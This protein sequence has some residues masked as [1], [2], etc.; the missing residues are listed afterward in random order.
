[1]QGEG[2]ATKQG[3]VCRVRRVK[4]TSPTTTETEALLL[5]K[6]TIETFSV[7]SVVYLIAEVFVFEFGLITQEINVVFD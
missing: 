2:P 6:S 5:F 4:R 1:M 3:F 7:C